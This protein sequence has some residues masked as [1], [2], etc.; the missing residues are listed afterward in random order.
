MNWSDA[1]PNLCS[2]TSL[3]TAAVILPFSNGCGRSDD[4]VE[5][6][7]IIRP[8]TNAPGL[9]RYLPN[10]PSPTPRGELVIPIE[11]HLIA[12]RVISVDHNTNCSL[13]LIRSLSG[14]NYPDGQRL[15]LYS[16]KSKQLNEVTGFNGLPLRE[17]FVLS[18]RNGQ[19]SFILASVQPANAHWY[20]TELLT[21]DLRANVAL[22]LTAGYKCKVAPDHL[23]V[24]FW[25]TDS[26]WFHSLHIWDVTTGRI[27]NVISLW[28]LD[29]GSG[30]SWD[31]GW[32][33]DSKALRI[34][35]VCGGFY[36]NRARG[37]KEF[38]LLYVLDTK[39]MFSVRVMK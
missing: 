2:L 1:V 19:N 3:L 16:D 30:T 20:M 29:P 9:E 27:E 37:R 11:K 35:G 17:A 25:R 28:E 13:W 10:L 12:G 32:S 5:T 8:L 26:D 33:E 6:V 22:R 38:D 36:R 24:A 18:D 39:Q 34:Q 15:Y 7:P 31:W 4:A 21:N 14:T 23:K